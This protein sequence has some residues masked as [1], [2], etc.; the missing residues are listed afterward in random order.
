MTEL[1][2]DK[3]CEGWKGVRQGCCLSLFEFIVYREYLTKGL[4]T[5]KYEEKKFAL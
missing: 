4:G 5:S 2:A 3:K 1:R